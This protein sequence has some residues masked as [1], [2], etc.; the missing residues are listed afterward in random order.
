VPSAGCPCDVPAYLSSTRDLWRQHAALHNWGTHWA[1]SCAGELGGVQQNDLP[2]TS[3]ALRVQM[4]CGTGVLQQQPGQLRSSRGGGRRRQVA[5]MGILLDVSA[6]EDSS[7]YALSQYPSGYAPKASLHRRC[8]HCTVQMTPNLM[9]V[10][11]YAGHSQMLGASAFK[12]KAVEQH[13]T[14]VA[15]QALAMACM[16]RLCARSH[17]KCFIHTNDLLTAAIQHELPRPC[18]PPACPSLFSSGR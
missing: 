3:M 12:P 9:Q 4:L 13:K 6:A 8:P 5:T 16:F 2:P 7:G 17:C 1:P 18:I 11:W 15:T 10:H 14:C